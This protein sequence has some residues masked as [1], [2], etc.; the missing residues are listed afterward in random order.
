MPFTE[1]GVRPDICINPHAFPSRMT[2][3]QLLEIVAGKVSC[4]EGTPTDGTAFHDL[5]IHDLYARLKIA[6][7]RSDIQGER[8]N[9]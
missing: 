2:V 5:S 7:H 9:D 4:V 1:S 8:T 6:G 3:G